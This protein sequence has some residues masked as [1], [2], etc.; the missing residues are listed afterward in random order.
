MMARLAGKAQLCATAADVILAGPAV[1]DPDDR[2][3]A[4]RGAGQAIA[5]PSD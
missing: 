5:A 4:R 1:R 3:G 2:R